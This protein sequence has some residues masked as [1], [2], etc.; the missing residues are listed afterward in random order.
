MIFSLGNWPGTYGFCYDKEIVDTS[1]GSSKC[2]KYIKAQ[3]SQSS[4]KSKDI[5]IC[6]KPVTG[7]SNSSTSSASQISCYT[8]VCVSDSQCP[9]SQIHFSTA[10]QSADG[11]TL[12]QYNSTLFINYR[13][14]SS[15]LPL[16][17]IR[18]NIG[19]A[20]TCLSNLEYFAQ[21]N[22]AASRIEGIGCIEY[23]A[24][25]NPNTVDTENA[26]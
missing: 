26:L 20:K 3:D 13:W 14:N 5:V 11:W 17:T 12:V 2:D 19:E 24:F 18:I 7:F 22:W 6:A 16:S 25:L 9:I 4:S 21:K 23:G 10:A 8:E 15:V 1:K